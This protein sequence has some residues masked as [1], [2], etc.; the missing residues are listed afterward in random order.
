MKIALAYIHYP[1]S[2]GRYLKNAFGYLGGHE[3]VS[4]G[5][6]TKGFIPWLPKVDFSRY[7]DTP[8]Y[9]FWPEGYYPD[10][11]IQV[12]AAFA[13]TGD[14]PFPNYCYA[15]DNHVRPYKDRDYDMFFGAHSWGEK[16]NKPETFQWLPC[17]YDVIHH[18]N[19]HVERQVDAML[20]GVPYPNRIELL[21]GMMQVTKKVVGAV[22]FMYEDYNQ[23]YN[24]SKV[25]LVEPANND[26]AERVF[27]NMAQGCCVLARHVPDMDKIG[28]EDGNQL[29]VFHSIDEAKEKLAWALSHET[30]RL[31]IAKCGE[32]WVKNHSWN[33]RAKVI[34]GNLK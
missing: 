21:Q 9:E 26:L 2:T 13:L 18:Y 20:V 24:E 14:F 15:V 19:M 1:V 28:L 32:E 7:Q 30:E 8:S 6:G 33:E 29:L 17:A 25:A 5:P 3:I 23:A 31:E 4:I 12:D 27:E 34:L 22:G 16:G 11:L 10:V